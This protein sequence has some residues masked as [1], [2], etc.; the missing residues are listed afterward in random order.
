MN[1]GWATYWHLRIIRELELTESEAIEFA[2]TNAYIISPSKTHLNPYLLGL[3]IWESIA[4]NNK[5]G[6]GKKKIFEIRENESDISFIRNYLTKEL[7]EDLDLFVF[8]K[9]GHEWKITDNQWEKVRDK[10]TARLFNGG[11]PYIVVEDGD[12][13]E[14]GHLYLR[15]CHE[16]IDLD[17][18]Y[19]EKTLPHINKLW[20]KTVHLETSIEDK[21][22]IFTF[23]GEQ[24]FRKII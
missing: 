17:I 20:G 8:E 13:Q 22:I 24:N 5:G 23:D 1:E 2:K 16:G 6:D 3:K 21:K 10:L 19:L 9:I 11:F 4:E 14:S 18:P 7:V 12:Y 15:H